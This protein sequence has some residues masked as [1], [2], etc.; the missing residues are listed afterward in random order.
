[1]IEKAIIDEDVQIG[2]HVELGTLPEKPNDTKP[3]IY[4]SGL[5]TIGEKS[6]LPDGVTVGEKFLYCRGYY[7]R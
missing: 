4:C 7:I 5:V 6:V 1:M 2:N 3:D